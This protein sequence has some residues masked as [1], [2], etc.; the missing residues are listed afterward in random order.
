[1]QDKNMKTLVLLI[2]PRYYL[3]IRFFKAFA[4]VALLPASY[5][6]YPGLFQCNGVVEREQGGSLRGKEHKVV[7]CLPWRVLCI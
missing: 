2:G 4:T 1:M 5:W 3:W 7:F 6:T